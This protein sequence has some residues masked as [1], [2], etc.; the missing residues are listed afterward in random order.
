LRQKESDVE[1][2]EDLLKSF[3]RDVNILNQERN[4]L[5]HLQNN[6]ELE[7]ETNAQAHLQLQEQKNENEKLK[8]IIDALKTDLDEALAHPEET[9]LEQVI[10]EEES[11]GKV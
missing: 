10:E 2:S 8:E 1:K 11:H 9:V 4:R 3:K 6:L 5:I 7:L